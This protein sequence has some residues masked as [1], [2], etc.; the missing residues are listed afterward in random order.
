VLSA[1]VVGLGWVCLIVWDRYFAGEPWMRGVKSQYADE[2][3]TAVHELEQS[4]RMIRDAAVPAL[5]KAMNDPDASV[6]A[7]AA[8]AMVST[9]SPI[10]GLPA[11]RTHVNAA[12]SVALGCLDDP[13]P[14]VR[15]EAVHA[16]W[17]VVMV[18]GPPPE[19]AELE[20]ILP[21]LIDRLSDADA[22]VR[23]AAIRGVGHVGP[24]VAS[25]PPPALLARLDDVA[26]PNRKAAAIALAAYKDGLAGMLPSMVASLE[27]GSPEFRKSFLMAL[28]QMQGM[29]LTPKAIPGLVAAVRSHDPEVGYLAASRLSELLEKAGSAM[30]ALGKAL[31][32]ILDA[33]PGDSNS[34]DQANRNRD[35]AL[36]IV[37]GLGRIGRGATALEEATAA[38]AKALRPDRSP[39]LRV[40]AARTLG[41]LRRH[42]AVF[43][44]LSEFILDRDPAVRHAVIWAIHDL[45]FAVGYT[46]PKA[47]AI[48]LEDAS[49]ETRSDA[50]AAIGH[51]GMG[52][53]AFVPALVEHVLNDPD[54]EV[55]GMCQTVI[56]VIDPPKFTAASVSHLIKGLDS[57][58]PMTREF[59]CD[60]LA[61]LGR[62]SAPAIPAL[63][64]LLKDPYN[65][66]TAGYH[67]AAAR[68]LGKIAPGTPRADEAAATLIEF[69]RP[70]KDGW[71]TTPPTVNAYAR[72]A[73]TEALARLQ[74]AK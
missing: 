35:N 25:E 24:K 73:A 22:S 51:S 11:S 10:S 67:A 33:G 3:L 17:M 69:L 56:R 74:P 12:I 50:V 59:V 37:E 36:A 47:L 21:R 54:P 18:S 70:V 5:L 14:S 1:A 48:A 19:K 7:G 53:D 30:P 39:A 29:Q 66:Q 55:R 27:K 61:K 31:D 43:N 42:P 52:V 8:K 58:E 72:D 9:M 34:R 68:A 57:S 13:D 32:E 40:A 71:T 64:R 15:A 62:E 26:E 60:A 2:R 65:A 6:R 38:L 4:G 49:A 16:A 23:L 28:E 41:R 44:A 45:D 46:V 63:I 20:P